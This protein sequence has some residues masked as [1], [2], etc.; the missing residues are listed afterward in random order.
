MSHPVPR[1][2]RDPQHVAGVSAELVQGRSYVFPGWVPH[3]A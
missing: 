1:S 3:P 2:A